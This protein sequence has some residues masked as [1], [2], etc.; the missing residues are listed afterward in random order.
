MVGGGVAGIWAAYKLIKAGIP[1]TL[2]TY[3]DKDRGGIQGSIEQEDI[4]LNSFAVFGV[5]A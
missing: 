2:I 5:S 1:T 4:F 3:L